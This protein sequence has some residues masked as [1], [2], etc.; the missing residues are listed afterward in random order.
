MPKLW[1]KSIGERG[2]RVRLYEPRPKANLM[3][4]VYIDGK[5][6]RRS[7]GHKDRKRAVRDAYAFLNQ[8][9]AE[10]K[11]DERASLTLGSLMARYQQSPV[12]QGKNP[13][14]RLDDEGVHKR[15]LSFFGEGL[16]VQLLGPSDVARYVKAR[17]S[18]HYGQGKQKPVR[19]GTIRRDLVLLKA[20][21]NWAKYEREASGRRLIAENPLEGVELPREKNPRRPVVTDEEFKKLLEVA[22]RVH[23]LL[24]LAL[25]IAEGTGRRLGSWRKLRWDD[26][27]FD[28]VPFGSIRWRAENDKKGYEQVVPMSRA[29]R[30]ALLEARQAQKAIGGWVFPWPRKPRQVCPQFYLDDWLR[31][32]YRVAKIQKQQGSLWHAFRRKWATERKGYPVGDVAAAGGWR[33]KQTLLDSYQ[34]VDRSEERRVGKECRS[35]W[36]PYH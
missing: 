10:T 21:L 14:V 24:P 17:R 32:A 3:R 2:N 6:N 25:V 5:E 22:P 8:L 4:S 1:T 34:Q 36:S 23:P 7:L 13:K 30:E 20:A 29:V 15:L 26:M 9:G 19:D 12:H 18:G 31:E 27:D 11:A 28:T 35:R 33:D 16:D